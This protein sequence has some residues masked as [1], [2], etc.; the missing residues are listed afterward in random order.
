MH[1]W[2]RR[3]PRVRSRPTNRITGS[4]V[5]LDLNAQGRL[6]W[7]IA[8]DDD[9]WAFEGAPLVEGTDVYIGMRQERR[10]AASACGLFRRRNGT[11]PLAAR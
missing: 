3:S 11:P 6:L 2:G 1:A 8:P 10:A 4:L 7:K 9:K 5:C